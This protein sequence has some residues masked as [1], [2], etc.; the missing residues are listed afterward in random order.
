MSNFTWILYHI[1]RIE[2]AD[3]NYPIL[4]DPDGCIID[5]W[6]R[7]AKAVLNEDLTIKAK[8]LQIMP[9]PDSLEKTEA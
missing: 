9:E 2:K 8:R 4:L 6:H 3:L 5:G 7:I 1:K